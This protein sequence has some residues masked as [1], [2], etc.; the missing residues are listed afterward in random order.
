MMPTRSQ[1]DEACPICATVTRVSD[2][3]WYYTCDGCG[4]GINLIGISWKRE[5]EKNWN[6]L[7]QEEKRQAGDEFFKARS[8]KDEI[9][10]I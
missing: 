9:I 5:K 7:S 6:E 1:H 4:S 3:T 10:E 8:W 2:R